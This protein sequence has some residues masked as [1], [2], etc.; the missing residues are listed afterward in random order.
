MKF[1]SRSTSAVLVVLAFFLFAGVAEAKD[2]DRDGL[3]DRREKKIRT[4]P[5]KADTDRD[6]LRDG[7]E[8]KRTRTNPRDADTDDDGLKDGREVGDGLDPRDSDSDDDGTEDI[9]ERKGRLE[10]ITYTTGDP[11]ITVRTKR[12]TI[13]QVRIDERTFLEGLDR[14][15][16]RLLTL[17][18]FQ[19]GDR[20][21]VNLDPI[22]PT[23][24][25]T[26]ELH[27]DDEEE[28]NE[29]KG[30]ITGITGED[31]TLTNRSGV[32][33]SFVVNLNTF[34]RAPD[35]NSDGSRTIEDLVVG[36]E[37][38]AHLDTDGVRALSLEVKGSYDDGYDD[39]DK[40]DEAEGFLLPG[41]TESQLILIR[42]G[43][44][45][46]V[47]I[48]PG[49]E[50]FGVDRNQDGS[51]DTGDLLP[52]DKIEARI[53][54]DGIALEVEYESPYGGGGDGEVG[55]GDK[56]EVK[57]FIT[58]KDPLTVQALRGPVVLF[59][60]DQTE[61]DVPD[62]NNDGQENLN[63]FLPG[64]FVE[65]KFRISDNVLLEMELKGPP[66]VDDED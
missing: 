8:V 42:R 28:D 3:S 18:D 14:D 19:I 31:V 23:R 12:G 51:N 59:P 57:G 13:F 50:F 35:R 34:V 55:I 29:W 1:F 9:Y 7:R 11:R 39:E 56:Q 66:P 33:K 5:K 49:T 4:N 24:A 21:E 41:F 58:S 20:I 17:S 52:G 61:Y 10:A 45:R 6:A 26:L 46:V 22:D 27:I 62:R 40:S 15:G 47:L 30:R 65:A 37:A 25:Q 54:S 16:D 60:G 38:E 48:G 36:D 53:G 2:T 44:E 64:D 43:H 63:D 32:S